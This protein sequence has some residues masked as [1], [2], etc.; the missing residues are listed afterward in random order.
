MKFFLFVTSIAFWNN[1]RLCPVLE[2]SS[3]C[4]GQISLL[5]CKPYLE[6]PCQIYASDNIVLRGPPKTL[7]PLWVF[8]FFSSNV[9]SSFFMLIGLLCSLVGF[10]FYPNTILLET[11]NIPTLNCADI[12]F[13]ENTRMKWVLSKCVIQRTLFSSGFMKWQYNITFTI[14]ALHCINVFLLFTYNLL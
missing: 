3:S 7:P 12:F 1:I 9:E 5:I 4:F 10:C 11:E 2:F 6:S 14:Q 13:G 8:F